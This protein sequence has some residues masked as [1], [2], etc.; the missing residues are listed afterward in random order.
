MLPVSLCPN[1]FFQSGTTLF[2]PFSSISLSKPLFFTIDER[3]S[4]ALRHSIGTLSYS[5]VQ[6]TFQA[7]LSFAIISLYS[8]FSILGISIK[9]TSLYFN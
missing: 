6:Y 2:F 4:I 7:S 3:A 5:P 9:E 8:G 1:T